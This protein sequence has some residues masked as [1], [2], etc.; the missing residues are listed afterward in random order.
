MIR[1]FSI[2]IAIVALTSSALAQLPTPIVPDPGTPCFTWEN[3][4]WK[5]AETTVAGSLATFTLKWNKSRM[6][7]QEVHTGDLYLPK[8]T[9]QITPAERAPAAP[10]LQ[11]LGPSGHFEMRCDGQSCQQ[12]WVPD[13]GNALVY[14]A[15]QCSNGQCGQA[16]FYPGGGYGMSYGGCASGACGMSG[17]CSG[18]SCGMSGGRRGLFGRRR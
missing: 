6:L 8:A 10:A 3:G 18:G 17:G 4:G 14:G 9:E 7:W 5:S 15:G 2:A 12:A 13:G 16:M 11:P 1:L